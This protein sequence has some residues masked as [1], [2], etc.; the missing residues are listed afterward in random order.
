MMTKIK[1]IGLLLI[2]FFHIQYGFGH[3]VE[4]KIISELNAT[5]YTIQTLDD[6]ITFIKTDTNSVC[7]KPTLLFCQGS[8][9]IPLIIQYENRWYQFSCFNF[10]YRKV[11]EKYNLI[12]VSMPHVPSVVNDTELNP[13]GTYPRLP[14]PFGAAYRQDNYLE[15]Y[16]QRANQVIHYILSQSWAD[17][18]SLYVIGHSQG[19]TIGVG[20]AQTNE[21]VK[22]LAYL[23]GDPDGRF[24]QKIKNARKLVYQR[25][26]T[27]LEA[28]QQLNE[29]YDWWRDICSGEQEEGNTGDLPHTWESFSRP[30]REALV[31]LKIPLFMAYGTEDIAASGCEL[32][33]IYFELNG[34][35]DYMIYPVI[36]CG[37][38]FEEFTDSGQSDYGKM[39]W[40][41]VID[42]FIQYIETQK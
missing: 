12:A 23:S 29:L 35:T 1:F 32:M 19:A 8:L 17:S 14:K 13:D 15:K 2:S 16:V 6:T 24:A 20:I 37:H 25:K 21:N 26:I 30:M 18:D 36:G 4:T 22:G 28:R 33:P 5:L 3:H 31:H 7:K 41:E 40:Q 9:P 38:N 27:P 39:H 34:K 10:D 11:S 42:R